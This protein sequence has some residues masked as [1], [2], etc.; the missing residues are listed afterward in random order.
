MP[1]GVVS[2]F[3]W[4]QLC[5]GEDNQIVVVV[6]CARVQAKK[7]QDFV[8]GQVFGHCYCTDCRARTF[9]RAHILNVV[10]FF[11]FFCSITELFLN[12]FY[13]TK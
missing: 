2:I 4:G 13:D 7:I 3:Q 12:R 6:F 9:S 5:E 1:S 10:T 11:F 8:F